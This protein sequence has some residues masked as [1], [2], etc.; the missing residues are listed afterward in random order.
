MRKLGDEL[1]MEG[2]CDRER[3]LGMEGG[4]EGWLTMG[5]GTVE[6]KEEL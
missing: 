4:E 5:R 1:E 6:K 2:M 3:E